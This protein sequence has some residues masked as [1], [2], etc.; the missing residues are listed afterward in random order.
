MITF[1]PAEAAPLLDHETIRP[2]LRK[3]LVEHDLINRTTRL[4]DYSDEGA[5]RL[6]PDGIEYGSLLNDKP[7]R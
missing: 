6:L 2:E 4:I 7:S 3:R 1:G 5:R